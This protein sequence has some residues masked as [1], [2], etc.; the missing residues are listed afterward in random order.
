MSITPKS[1]NKVSADVVIPTINTFS[2]NHS[3]QLSGCST[4]ISANIDINI[5]NA[6]HQQQLDDNK[7]NNHNTEQID[8]ILNE[9]LTNIKGSFHSL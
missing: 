5:V 9:Y 7:N 2:I 3:H 1:T 4:P 8:L 6:V